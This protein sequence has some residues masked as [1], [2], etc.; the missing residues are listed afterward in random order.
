MKDNNLAGAMIYTVDL[1]D[2]GDRCGDGAFPL[3][4]ALS[5]NL[6]EGG[7]VA[8]DGQ[9]EWGGGAG[10][11]IVS[12]CHLIISSLVIN[13]IQYTSSYHHL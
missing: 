7:P 12:S 6:G 2:F 4:S 9:E 10:T 11:V 3:T 1:D 13:T 8:S 5:T